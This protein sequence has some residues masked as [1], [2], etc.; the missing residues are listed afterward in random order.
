MVVNQCD[1]VGEKINSGLI[2]P[3]CI[4]F[5]SELLTAIFKSLS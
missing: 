1:G 5:M 2:P 3:H 4:F